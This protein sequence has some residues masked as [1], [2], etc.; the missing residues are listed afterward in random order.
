MPERVRRERKGPA[1]LL[2]PHAETYAGITLATA[3][4]HSAVWVKDVPPRFTLSLT[5]DNRLCNVGSVG[6]AFFRKIE[7][8]RK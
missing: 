2:K 4:A 1:R 5:Q 3:A 6:S 7:W 8:R